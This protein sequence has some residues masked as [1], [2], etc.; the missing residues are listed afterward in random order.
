[1]YLP[2]VLITGQFTLIFKL[3][4]LKLLN[5]HFG[6]LNVLVRLRQ[7]NMRVQCPLNHE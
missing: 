5:V 6:M 4:K 1:M 7:H 2:L 3:T